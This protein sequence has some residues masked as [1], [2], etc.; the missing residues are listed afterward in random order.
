M[1]KTKNSGLD[2]LLRTNQLFFKYLRKFNSSVKKFIKLNFFVIDTSEILSEQKINP[3]KCMKMNEP[4]NTKNDIG[5]QISF[6]AYHYN[7]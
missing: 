7:K 4:S 1:K 2:C 6:E 3:L 5:N